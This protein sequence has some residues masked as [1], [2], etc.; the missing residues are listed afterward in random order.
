MTF[1]FFIAAIFSLSYYFIIVF[2]TKKWNSTFA[3]FWPVCAGAH[4]FLWSLTTVKNEGFILG[5]LLFFWILF[6]ITLIPICRAMGKKTET[7]VDYLIVLGAQVRGRRITN[8]LMRRLDAALEYLEGHPETKA[9]VSGGQGRDE[10][11]SEAE[12]MAEYLMNHGILPGRILLENTSTSTWENLKHSRAVLCESKV[13][14]AIV[15]NNFHLYRAMKQ[16]E[17]VGFQNISGIAATAQPVLQLNYLVR[18]CVAVLWMKIN[19]L[20]IRKKQVD[21]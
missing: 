12:A 7:S 2:F 11:I 8:S 20:D 9:I 1:Y 15:T 21:K 17:R 5:V 16:G 6:A 3:L 18:E 13:S 19:R 10:H 4:I 14:V